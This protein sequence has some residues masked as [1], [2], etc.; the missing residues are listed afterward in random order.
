M[1]GKIFNLDIRVLVDLVVFAFFVVVWG[2]VLEQLGVIRWVG[3]WGAESGGLSVTEMMLVFLFG[4]VTFIVVSIRRTHE[5]SGEVE[6]KEKANADNLHIAWHDALTDLPNRRFFTEQLNQ[7]LARARRHDKPFAVMMLDLD[8]FKQ[9]NDTYGH[10]AGD[11]FLGVIGRRLDAA[12]REMDTVARLGGD[13][14]AIIVPEVS[15]L[16]VLE[17]IAQ[18]IIAALAKKI[19]HEGH[20]LP[21]ATSLGVVRVIEMNDPEEIMRS[22]DIALYKAKEAGRGT[23][24]FFEPE[25]QVE[26][27]ERQALKRDLEIAIR[28]GSLELHF[29]PIFRFDDMLLAENCAVGRHLIG[30]EAL[31]RWNHCQLGH[32]PSEEFIQL[33]EESDL[34][35]EL[36]N[37]ILEKACKI[38]AT[39]P[40]PLVLAVNVSALQLLRSSFV[41]MVRA[42]IHLS[43]L[44]AR[45][46]E[47]EVTE[48]LFLELP[49]NGFDS[50]FTIKKLGVHVVL[51]DFGTGYSSINHLRLFPFDKVKFDPSLLADLAVTGK[52]ADVFSAM[53]ALCHSLDIQTA[54]EGIETQAQL[55]QI[56][57]HACDQVQGFLL[58]S[59]MPA[60]ELDRLL[61]ARVRAKNL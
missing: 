20:E 41:P 8:Q 38:A 29:Q 32:I 3:E 59:P 22:A 12:M 27:V 49:E 13:E 37:W 46:L 17:E 7:E 55:K 52:G 60:G 24:R 14:F 39:W 44:D 31:V 47:L 18:R 34:I 43:G 5:L 58:G 4:C 35:I 9:I 15:D 57:G 54:A 40:E 61:E 10:P 19:S 51:D 23:Y 42:A 30:F 45:R 33:A 2:L 1:K 28:E 53:L 26:L 16:S 36:G 25:M 21:S 48:A 50:L 6:L 56:E 11:A